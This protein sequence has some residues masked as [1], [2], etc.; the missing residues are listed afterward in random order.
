M[1]PTWHAPTPLEY[2]ASLVERDS[3]FPLFEAAVCLAQDEYPD[4]DLQKVTHQ[5][6]ALTARVRR[7]VAADAGSLQRLQVLNQFFFRELGFGVNAN[8]YYAADNS[9]IHQVL[10][11]RRGIPV[12]LAVLWLEIASGMGLSVRGISFPG[13]FLVKVNLPI[14]QAI[15]DPA[16]GKSLSAEQLSEMLSQVHPDQAP[17]SSWDVAGSPYLR[18]AAPR[19]I[20]VR[21]LRN[22]KGIFQAE[23]D[24]ERML[25]VQERLVVLLPEVWAEYRDRGLAHAALGHSDQ[26][27]ADLEC[28]LVHSDDLADSDLIA[29]RLEALRNTR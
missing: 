12:S 28:Y 13:H 18:S 10:A 4:L 23:G 14:G 20:L 21:M 5:V 2:F 26:A 22:L 1:H 8:D 17:L 9:Y 24:W 16:T 25:A 7:R 27:V 29:E 11:T 3:D 6:D 19:D 15:I